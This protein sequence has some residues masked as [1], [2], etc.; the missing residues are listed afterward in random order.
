MTYWQTSSSL[1][2]LKSFLENHHYRRRMRSNY[3]KRESTKIERTFHNINN[4]PAYQK[5]GK[6]NQTRFCVQASIRNFKPD[7]A[8]TLGSQPARDRVVGQS[9]DLKRGRRET[10]LQRQVANDTAQ[11]WI[12]LHKQ[13]HLSLLYFFSRAVIFKSGCFVQKY[14]SGT[15]THNI[16]GNM[17]W[18]Q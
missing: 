3:P 17:T 1:V 4:T 14:W 11:R 6:S 16:I 9:G 8:S 13:G 5:A 2:K 10:M 18:I 15:V 7:L 12:F